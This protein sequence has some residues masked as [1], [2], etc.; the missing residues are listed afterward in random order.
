MRSILQKAV[1]CSPSGSTVTVTL[2]LS[3]HL[4]PKGAVNDDDG[5]LC[6]PINTANAF[7]PSRWRLPLGIRVRHAP[8][9]NDI[10]SAVSGIEAG[11]DVGLGSMV[12]GDEAYRGGG[13][14]ISMIPEGNEEKSELRDAQRVGGGGGS[15]GGVGGGGGS[16]GGGVTSQTPP[17]STHRSVN[18]F[19]SRLRM[20]WPR[21]GQAVT[22]ADPPVPIRKDS[23]MF[24]P[25][26]VPSF[27]A[28]RGSR[29]NLPLHSPNSPNSPNSTPPHAPLPHT[30]IPGSP[31]LHHGVKT[32]PKHEPRD[33]L[34]HPQNQADVL[35]EL[36]INSSNPPGEGGQ[37]NSHSDSDPG[38]HIVTYVLALALA[39]VLA[40]VL[41]LF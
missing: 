10:G 33:P 17:E 16:G 4:G 15:G 5:W 8:R 22:P 34:Q 23:L 38:N 6:W 32:I 36:N 19:W 1:Q 29:T 21:K 20:L 7:L 41:P 11:P 40:L 3:K 18:S 24:V 13:G 14:R 25:T 30:D 37:R 28:P 12:V 2:R 35:R 26:L 27:A 39:L 31:R 9:P